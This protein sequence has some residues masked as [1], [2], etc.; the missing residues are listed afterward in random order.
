MD[1][2]SL[3]WNEQLRMR[4]CIPSVHRA[5]AQQHGMMGGSQKGFRD[6]SVPD[7]L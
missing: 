2:G 4:C 1:D 7:D 6:P 5:D 3:V